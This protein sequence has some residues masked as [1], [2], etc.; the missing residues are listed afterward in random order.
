MQDNNARIQELFGKWFHGTISNAERLELERYA[1]EEAFETELPLL[2]KVQWDTLQ[3]TEDF[4]LEDRQA[5]GKSITDRYPAEEKPAIIRPVQRVHFPGKWGWM[6]AASV[7]LL[8]GIGAYLFFGNT[9]KKNM[10]PAALARKTVDIAPGKDGAV[11]TLA[12]GRQVVL[13]SMGNGVIAS[14]NGVLAMI[15]NGA[16]VYDVASAADG[17]V[18]YNSMVTPKG[19]QFNVLLPDGTRAWLNA[20][21]SIR[22]PTVFVGNER[23]VEVTGE[24]FFEVKKNTQ[25]PFRVNVNNRA[26]IVVLGTSFNV[27]AY[28]NEEHIAATLLEGSVRVSQPAAAN[29]PVMLKPGQQAQIGGEQLTQQGIEVITDTD[30]DKVMAWKNGLFNFEDATL[31]E[32]LRQLERWYDIEVIY[33]AKIPEVALMGKITRGVSLNGLLTA[34]K[35]MGMHYR[36]NGRKLVVQP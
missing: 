13:D 11:L 35:K 32:V 2:L 34:L 30:I 15:K 8:L 1:L 5:L 27:N 29:Q 10:Q 18:L 33:E 16:L 19:H 17:E 4:S 9:N 14:Q 21:S 6:A 36:L 28:E 23:K 7:I 12:D 25:M 26:E 20:A 24:V 3:A 31:E 22:Y